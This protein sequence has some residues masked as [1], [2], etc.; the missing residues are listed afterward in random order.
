MIPSYPQKTNEIIV[1]LSKVSTSSNKDDDVFGIFHANV[2][3][4]LV[5]PSG[6]PTYVPPNPITSKMISNMQDNNE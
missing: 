6:L 5:C 3:L 1:Q 2:A 4:I